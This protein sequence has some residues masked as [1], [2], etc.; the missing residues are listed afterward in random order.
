MWPLENGG[1]RCPFYLLFETLR[2]AIVG[3]G[4][5]DAKG[6]AKTNVWEKGSDY[7]KGA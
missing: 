3:Y 2:R 5:P 6:I 1:F 7:E 4:K